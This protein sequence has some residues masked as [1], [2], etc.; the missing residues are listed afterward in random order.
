MNS[1]RPILPGR[2]ATE[3]RETELAA[4]PIRQF[5]SWFEHAVEAELP[6]P[7]AMTLATSTPAGV[8][9][10]RIVLLKGY[11]PDGFL[12]FTNY[13]SQK[14]RELEANPHVAL[15]LFWPMLERQ[16]RVTGTASKVSREVSESYFHSRPIGS[17]VG[18]WASH[19]SQVLPNRDELDRRAQELAVEYANRPVPLPPYWGGYR[20]RPSAIEFWQG[21][22]D[23]LHDRFRY[24]RQVPDGWKIE[25]LSP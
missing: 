10:A 1:D 12:F 6:E 15:V 2:S 16:I 23:R 25:R 5:A 21:R 22:P 3:L 17:Q 8:P 18:A 14:G 20:V 4:D 13:E 7:N 19:Q 11:D 9:S 24:S